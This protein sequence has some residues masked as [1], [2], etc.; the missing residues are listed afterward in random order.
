MAGLITNAVGVAAAL[1]SMIS[2]VPQAT[3]II[4]DRDTSG[5]SLKMYVVTVIG[6][7]L[8]SGYGVLLRS[9]PLVVSNLVTL[10]LAGLILVL[11]LMSSKGR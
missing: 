3:K 9:W 7:A 8:W 4:R 10:G 1:C 6:F 5:V 11:K 2:F